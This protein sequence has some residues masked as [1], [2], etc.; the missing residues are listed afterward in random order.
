MSRRLL[1]M[2]GGLL[3]FVLVLAVPVPVH[4][5]GWVIGVYPLI[6][7]AFIAGM[8]FQLS[9]SE[10]LRILAMGYPVVTSLLVLVYGQAFL[11]FFWGYVYGLLHDG[12]L[13]RERSV[14]SDYCVVRSVLTALLLL[15]LFYLGEAGELFKLVF[16]E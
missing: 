3:P 10:W 9:Q 13:Y 15:F 5:Y 7:L 6:V 11:C 14:H 2:G 8:Q 16:L 12:L 1:W 4:V